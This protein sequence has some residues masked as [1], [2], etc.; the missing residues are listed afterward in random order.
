MTES[1]SQTDWQQSF[2]ATNLVAIAYNAWV[3]Y[4][5]GERGAVVCSL[6]SPRLGLSGETF[7]AHYVPRSR[8]AAFLN[9]WLATPDTVILHHHH[10][11]GHIL[12]AIDH[13]NP[14]S[15]AIM[16]LESGRHASFLYL[17]NLPIAP[18]QSCDVICKE[19]EEFFIS[20]EALAQMQLYQI[21]LTG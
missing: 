18:P 11:K 19:H 3:G 8:M 12:Q 4:R 13:Y 9:A 5:T 10:I 1:E 21:N 15:D 16:L 7:D 14:E 6:N 2:V 20:D 17:R